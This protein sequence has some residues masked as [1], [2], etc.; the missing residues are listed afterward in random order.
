MDRAQLSLPLDKKFCLLFMG[1]L[2]GRVSLHVVKRRL[3]SNKVTKF[4]LLMAVRRSTFAGGIDNQANGRFRSATDATHIKPPKKQC[5][6]LELVRETIPALVNSS[7]K[8]QLGRIGVIG[9]CQE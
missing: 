9:G 2:A 8:G 3:S 7:H 6:C 5:S 4:R 1:G